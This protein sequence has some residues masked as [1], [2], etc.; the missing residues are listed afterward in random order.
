MPQYK[1]RES[2]VDDGVAVI[3]LTMST[4]AATTNAAARVGIR[5]LSFLVLFV[6]LLAL[7]GDVGV[8]LRRWGKHVSAQSSLASTNEGVKRVNPI[9][10]T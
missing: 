8:G 6:F 4:V 1:T 9:K 2:V 5:R 3:G 10:L 7:D